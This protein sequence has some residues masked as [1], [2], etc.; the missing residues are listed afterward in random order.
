[1]IPIDLGITQS[2]GVQSLALTTIADSPAGNL[3]IVFTGSTIGSAMLATLTDSASNS[4]TVQGDGGPNSCSYG[5]CS[6]AAP[7]AA[8]LTITGGFSGVAA[9][10][11]LFA[12][13][14]S[15][16]SSAADPRD[17]LSGYTA[18]TGIAATPINSGAL[19]QADE[20]IFGIIGFNGAP[21]TFTPGGNWILLKAEDTNVFFRICYQIV[22]ST[23]SVSWAPTW[24]TSRTYKSRLFSIKG[25]SSSPPQMAITQAVITLS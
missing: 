17:V 5:F 3:L 24:Q 1:M 12:A 22:S 9:N 23:A 19:A 4:Y 25:N 8:G 20:I 6:N 7:L 10:H 11:G 2:S 15:G 14:V 18:S 21:G 16:I 13:S